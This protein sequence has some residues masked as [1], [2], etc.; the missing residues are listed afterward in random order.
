MAAAYRPPHL[1]NALSELI[2]LRGWARKRGDAQLEA[3]WR[4]VAGP[5]VAS[6][7]KVQRINRGVLHVN[8]SNSTLLSELAM[9]HKSS[10][11]K[12]LQ[13]K[14]PDLNINNLK[15]RLQSIPQGSAEN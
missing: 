3:I 5:I 12:D 13:E 14:H 2:A 11:L 6:Q 4:D 9:F 7:T 10:L 15:F 8:V 1:S